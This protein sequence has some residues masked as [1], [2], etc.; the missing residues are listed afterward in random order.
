MTAQAS[1]AR[2]SL[3]FHRRIGTLQNAEY[4]VFFLENALHASSREQKEALKFAQMEE[5]HYGINVSTR[6]EHASNRRWR[7]IVP[8]W[9][10][11]TGSEHLMP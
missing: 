7:R 10:E 5:A 1:L 3:P 2:Q 6:Q 11:L 4:L 9:R 8:G